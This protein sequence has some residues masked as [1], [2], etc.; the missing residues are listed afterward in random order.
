MNVVDRDPPGVVHGP[1]AATV[2][3]AGIDFHEL[4]EAKAVECVL[5]SFRSGGGGRAVFVNVDVALRVNRQTE[6]SQFIESADLVLAD[7]MPLIWAGRLQKTALPERVAGSTMLS[8]LVA[9]A[10][11]EEVPVMLVG[12]QPGSAESAVERLRALHPGV[13]IGFYTPPFGFEADPAEMAA[14]EEAVDSFGRCICF[15]GLGFPK[16]ERLMAYLALHRPDWWFIASGGGIDFLAQHSRAP[17]WMQASGL[18][19]L[20]RLRREPKRLA[21]RYLIDDMPFAAGM[22][23]YS[24][25]QGYGGV[26]PEQ[27]RIPQIR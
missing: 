6:L 15:V 22:L 3:I 1:G 8:R 16:Q 24:A 27:D 19:W 2:R 13:R 11:Q 7:G 12:G 14:L 4:Y 25:W 23:A 10:A 18:E 9:R 5:K 26:E 17:G 20:Y 21:R